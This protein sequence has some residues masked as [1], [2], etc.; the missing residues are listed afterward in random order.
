MLDALN[1]ATPKEY[2]KLKVR[3]GAE[4]G[5][6]SVKCYVVP[7]TGYEQTDIASDALNR[8]AKIQENAPPDSFAIGRA[9]YERIHVQWLERASQVNLNVKVGVKNYRTYIVR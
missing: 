1:E 5:L 8:A 4:H 2:P 7:A 6:A 3:I 9:L